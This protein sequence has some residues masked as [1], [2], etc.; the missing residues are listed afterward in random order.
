[1]FGKLA[2]IAASCFAACMLQ[3]TNAALTEMVTGDDP[4]DKLKPYDFGVIT[5]FKGSDEDSV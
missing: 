4:A 2:Q 5:F 1:M 3:G